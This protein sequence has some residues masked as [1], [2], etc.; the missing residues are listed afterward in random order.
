MQHIFVAGEIISADEAEARCGRYEEQGIKHMYFL[1]TRCVR[2]AALRLLCHAAS[3]LQWL[4]NMR[5][6]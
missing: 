5:L 6:A 4:D 3:Y 2:A 1:Q